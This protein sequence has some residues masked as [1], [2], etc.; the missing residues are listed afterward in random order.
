MD[1]LTLLES[2]VDTIMRQAVKVM[3]GFIHNVVCSGRVKSPKQ[4]NIRYIY[5]YK[6]FFN[7]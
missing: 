4:I 2:H 6:S 1:Q 5:V 7:C 3:T